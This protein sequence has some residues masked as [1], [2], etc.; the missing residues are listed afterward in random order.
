MYFTFCNHW[1][2]CSDWLEFIVFTIIFDYKETEYKYLEITVLNFEFIF[3]TNKK[4]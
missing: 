2:C 1:K 4:Q 3:H